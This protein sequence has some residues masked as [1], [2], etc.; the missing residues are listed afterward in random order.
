LNVLLTD[1]IHITPMT[2]FY[3]HNYQ[4]IIPNLIENPINTLSDTIFF[5]AREFFYA[6]R[7]RL[8]S[9]SF[10]AL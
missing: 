3:D 10:N 9:Q 6:R 2:N 1:S 7:P 4:L 5:L 8:R